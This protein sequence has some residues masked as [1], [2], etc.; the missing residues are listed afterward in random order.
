M[1]K[2]A[3]G[4]IAIAA[5][6]GTP[7]FAADMAVKAPPS[8]A[9]TA[10]PPHDWSGFYL[11]LNVGGSWDTS[12]ATTTAIPGDFFGL[13]S[14]CVPNSNQNFHA[15]QFTGGIQG[16]Y[17]W[18][19]GHL[20]TGIELD[21][22]TFRNIGSITTSRAF[23]VSPTNTQTVNSTFNSQWLFTARPRLGLAADSFLFYGTGGLA[24]TRLNATWSYTDDFN[25]P[26]DC[27]SAEVSSTRVGWI[28]GGG[29]EDALPGNWL[30]GLEYLH[31]DFG[32]IFATS[33]NLMVP[34]GVH[35]TDTFNH[36]INLTTNIMR[37][38]LSRQF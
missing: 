28:L 11:G 13:C 32:T 33:N 34:G 31:T 16:G 5:L 37:V 2:P 20:V 14:E 7:V 23:P 19:V 27:E 29:I 26:C 21:A 17:N 4:L 6:I 3:L 12:S 25:A 15:S 1:K 18:Q 35:W 9:P 38:R 24:V 36:S 10:S 22:E 30:I 8:P